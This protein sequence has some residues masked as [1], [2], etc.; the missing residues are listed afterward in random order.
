LGEY[1]IQIDYAGKVYDK[2]QGLFISNYGTPEAPKRM[3]LTQFEAAS[4]RRFVPCWDEPA[5]KATFSMSVAIS[6]EEVAV[7]NMPIESVSALEKGL[8]C[9]RFQ[10]SPEMSSYLLF[11]GIGDFERLE[12]DAGATKIAVVAR[13]GSAQKGKFAL[14]S[15]VS[16][17]AYFND[18][19]GTPYPLPKLDLIAAPGA[20]VSRQWKTGVRS[21]TSR[22]HFSSILCCLASRTANACSSSWRTRWLTNGS[23]IWSRWSGGTI[24]G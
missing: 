6:K 17:L 21:F 2:A 14:E 5:R 24:C 10:K 9:V 22:T 23:A 18:Y 4:A 19:F 3:L 16:L 1:Q 7:S 20:E 8:Q 13:K 12:A 11:L 15:A